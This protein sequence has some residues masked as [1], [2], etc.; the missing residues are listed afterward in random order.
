MT[1]QGRGRQN[2]QQGS[3]IP[4]RV[5]DAAQSMAERS[6]SGPRRGYIPPD[7]GR[8]QQPQGGWQQ[9]GGQQFPPQQAYY[10]GQYP[11]QPYYPG[12]SPITGGQRGFIMPSG[13]AN[14]SP[15][16]KKD[17]KFLIVFAV[18]LLV[19]A[20]GTGGYFA[21]TSYQHTRDVTDA[22][23]AY[24]GLYCQGVYVD[25]IHLGGMTPEQALNSVESQIQQRNSAWKVQLVYEGTQLLEINADMLG[26]NDVDARSVLMNAWQYGHTG[27]DEEKYNEMLRLRQEPYSAYTTK[28][29]GNTG[30][31]DERLAEI[32]AGID[33]PAEDARLVETD[34]SL[35]N[36]FKF[37][38][39]AYGRSLD[40]EPLKE[41]LYQM[42]A[43]M[44]SG[45]V[46]LEADRIEPAVTLADLMKDYS[47]RADVT[48][49]I[50]RHSE[51]NRTNN[52]RH[53]F[54]FINGYVLE[55]DKTFSFNN[56]V[57]ERTEARGFLEAEE[58][59]YGEHQRGVGGGVCQAATTVYQA[60]V[61]AGLKILKRQKHSDSVSYAGYGEDAT[62]YWSEF[63][64][65]KKI[66]MTFMNNTDKPIY[67]LA[68]VE[69]IPKAKKKGNKLRTRVII[70]GE[71]LGNVVYRLEAT[72]VDTL[73][74][75]PS[76][77]TNDKSK[78][79]DGKIGHIVDS[80]QVQYTNG[81]ETGRKQLAHDVYDP[82]P[83]RY[84]DPSATDN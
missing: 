33:K 62:V 66:D 37:Q 27:T 25:G 41:Q 83:G 51:D 5:E 60:A 24:E 48:T 28:P 21:V 77:P 75:I 58:Y 17:H 50:D 61:N 74:M 13:Q 82:I 81:I 16:K 10:N 36:P 1:N 73:P 4:R 11:R 23:A 22:V 71:D 47:L 45:I 35:I 64:G 84:Y 79:S 9:A 42:A 6:G 70:Y 32:K 26:Y 2:A 34:W 14:Q 8:M 68:F 52:I 20:L 80:Y 3:R 65:G 44:Q 54:E 40:I 59:V 18:L 69:N 63:R 19:A 56:V 43:T 38:E 53:A 67:I 57:G 29:E 15:K 30:V 49:E 39:E 7:A 12:Q 31:I 72:E 76:K 46:N 55:P 78:V